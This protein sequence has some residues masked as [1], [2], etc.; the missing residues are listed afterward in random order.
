M[1]EVSS[2]VKENKQAL[3]QNISGLNQV[4]KVLV[5]QRAALDETLRV[6]PTALTNLFHTY[7]PASGTLDTRTNLGE[8][9]NDLTRDPA[10]VLCAI[11]HQGGKGAA[12][13]C[14]ALRKALPRSA[15]FGK[16]AST[17]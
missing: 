5:R 4:S 6:A 8:N 11:I 15:P 7:N 12:K 9:I 16:A 14:D 3:S 17:G 1:Q 10:T 13:A 2:Y